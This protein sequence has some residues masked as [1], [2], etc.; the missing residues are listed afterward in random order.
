M[1]SHALL[2]RLTCALILARPEF[3]LAPDLFRTLV[4]ERMRIAPPSVRG[5]L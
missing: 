2:T 5:P 1:L 4:V 3:K